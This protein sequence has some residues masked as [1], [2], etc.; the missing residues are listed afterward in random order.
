MWALINALF[1]YFTPRMKKEDTLPLYYYGLLFLVDG[2]D[3][4]S[5][6]V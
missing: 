3:T 6:Q 1:V 2:T 5:P 4:V